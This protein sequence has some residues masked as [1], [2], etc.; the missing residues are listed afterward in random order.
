MATTLDRPTLLP[1]LASSLDGTRDS[2][3]V[4]ADLLEETGSDEIAD[5]ARTQELRLQKQLR[6]VIQLAPKELL[7]RLGCDYLTHI[8][9]RSADVYK[10]Y[11]AARRQLKI[12]RDWDWDISSLSTLKLARYR[13]AEK[14]S[15]PVVNLWP[16]P[17]KRIHSGFR[18]LIEA[19][20]Q[21]M[22]ACQET[23]SGSGREEHVANRARSLINKVATDARNQ[24]EA[25][26]RSTESEVT[27]QLNQIRQISNSWGNSDVDLPE[28]TAG[29]Y[30][31]DWLFG[32]ADVATELQWQAEQTGRVLLDSLS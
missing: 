31:A 30:L 26:R 29:L 20:D 13:L 19:V 32:V 6:F 3:L 22:A 23:I 8:V 25:E 17:G 21:M 2:L 12:I 10:P 15:H 16:R 27:W 9:D 5:R 7:L 1:L 28:S 14:I 24:P 4:L 11:L 18:H